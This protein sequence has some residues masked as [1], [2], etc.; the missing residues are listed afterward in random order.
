VDELIQ[1]E[2][3]SQRDNQTWPTPFE[4]RL[5]ED[6]GWLVVAG[7]GEGTLGP[8]RVYVTA[9]WERYPT[10]A[11]HCIQCLAQGPRGQLSH[12]NQRDRH[13]THGIFAVSRCPG[14]FWV[15]AKGNALCQY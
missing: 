15:I 1:A 4:H 11:Y 6:P 2:T 5:D 7:K 8:L 14:P 13:A 9:S 3:S 10:A 12:H